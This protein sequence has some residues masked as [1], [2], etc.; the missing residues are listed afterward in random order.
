MTLD[1]NKFYDQYMR[2]PKPMFGAPYEVDTREPF[3]TGS[4]AYGEP[5]KD[6]DVDLVVRISDD[7]SWFLAGHEDSDHQSCSHIRFGNLNLILCTSDKQYDVWLEGTL[8]LLDEKER[9]KELV[10][11]DRAVEVFS[12]LRNKHGIIL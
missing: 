12:D 2:P 6:S 8:F 9:T 10:I 5:T 11:R 3:I 7:V 1:L 4:H